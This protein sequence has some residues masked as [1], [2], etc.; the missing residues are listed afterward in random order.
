MAS[1]NSWF[2]VL[3]LFMNIFSV[4]SASYA[5]RVPTD[6]NG[7][8]ISELV[9]ITPNRNLSWTTLDVATGTSS[10]ALSFGALGDH[11]ILGDWLG[12]GIPQF[13]IVRAQ[14]NSTNILWR[15]KDSD[16]KNIDSIYGIT[17][18][19]A[20]AAL[21]LDNSGAAD[22]VTIKEQDGKFI[23]TILYDPMLGGASSKAFIFGGIKE[24]IFTIDPDGTGVKLGVFDA[25]KLSTKIRLL[26]PKT[27]SVQVFRNLPVVPERVEQGLDSPMPLIGPDGKPVLALV[28]S[29]KDKTIVSILNPER[30]KK[31][32]KSK[33]TVRLKTETLSSGGT[34]AVGNFLSNPGYELAIQSNSGITVWNIFD[35]TTRNITA[36][37][38]VLVD[39]INLNQIDPVSNP[40]PSEPP[41]ESPLPPPPAD[42]APPALSA[43]CASTSLISSGEMLIKSEASNHIHDGDARTTGYTVV[44]GAL[45]PAHLNYVPFFYSNGEL[46]GAVGY[47]GLFS[48]NGR[49]RLY[50]AAGDADQHFASAIAKRA[51]QIGNGKL[52]LQMK[53]DGSSCKQFNPSGRNGSL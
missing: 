7:D 48:G 44:C 11:V 28:N 30:K 46:A 9:L 17:G 35:N 13:G 31:R 45:C 16:G 32:S 15:I 10:E 3:F 29:L 47:Y 33:R 42:D 22:S 24:K 5:E 34:V 41:T 36:P 19:K 43:V 20:L 12:R 26:D 52:Y 49:P 51:A 1:V 23:W 39:E 37:G 50:G 27:G 18:E 2:C 14:K 53:P 38:G 6:L 4:C 21:D 8:G 25:G 40:N